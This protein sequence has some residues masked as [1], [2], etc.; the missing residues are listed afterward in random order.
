M[1]LRPFVIPA[2]LVL[3]G[4]MLSDGAGAQNAT[5]GGLAGVVTDPSNAVVPGA[6]VQL[7]ENAKGTSQAKTTDRYGG[8]SFSFVPPGTYTLTV[9]HPGFRT[10]SQILVVS[11]GPPS[12]LNVRLAIAE[13]SDTVIVTGD[14][15]PL[16]AENGDAS[17]TVG[18]L[19][20][21]QVPNP[22][23]DLTYIAQTSPGVIMN[24]AGG[25]GN[26][27]V[28][29]MP[30]LSTTFSLNGMNYTDIG[31]GINV[32][33]ASNLLLG[34]N[35]IQE[36][37]IVSSGYSG[38]VGVQ[39]GANVSYITKSGGNQFHGN[40][41]YF[42]NGRVLNANDWI[43]N[44]TGTPRPFDNANQWAGS[45]GGPIKTDKLFF[46]FDTEGLRLLIPQVTQVVIPSL[47]F[48]EAT[49]ANIDAKFG[50]ASA[51]DAF[52]RQIFS[53]YN[54]APGANGAD[55]G[56]FAPSTDPT[57]CTGFTGPNGLG[58]TAPC[59]RHYQ[60]NLGRPTYESLYSGRVDWNIRP[61]DRIFIL[62]A[63]NYGHQSSITDPISKLFDINSK[64]PL[65]QGQL[66]E[67][68]TFGSSAANQFLIGGYKLNSHDGP[69]SI[70]DMLQALPT[71]ISW[72]DANTFT[73]IGSTQGRSV[74]SAPRNT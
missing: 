6:R 42:W 31:L 68:H 38:H 21:A 59:A 5:S 46:F 48:E 12:T 20:I 17:T 36:A 16:H 2:V 26:F 11:V 71:L 69:K 72:Q 30:G 4:L 33:S 34:I 53:L 14:T 62:V 56:G 13:S 41:L 57:G 39:A 64:Q 50:S 66:V 8:Y 61:Q 58:T 45:I 25:V 7:K 22:G 40:A 9:T 1:T 3:L 74:D 47:Q 70:P 73:N 37:T 51:S 32:T 43:N 60:A 18:R 23:N 10:V 24:T 54:T 29:G 52:Y 35:Q 44:A 19:Q 27:S 55:P 67:T 28:L 15:V 49:L 65:W 63:Y